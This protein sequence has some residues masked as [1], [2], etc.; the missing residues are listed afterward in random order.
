MPLRELLPWRRTN[1][2]DAGLGAIAFLKLPKVMKLVYNVGHGEGQT[3]V[4][5]TQA[6]QAEPCELIGRLKR[7]WPSSRS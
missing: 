1:G 3:G 5:E 6:L 4:E 2:M 7:D